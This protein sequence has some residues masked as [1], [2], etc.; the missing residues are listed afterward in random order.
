MTEQFKSGNFPAPRQ[1]EPEVLVLIQKMQQQLIFL[2]KKIDILI[3]QSQEKPVREKSFSKPFRSFDR[4]YSSGPYRGKRGPGE[5]SKER[6][7]RSGH[8]SEK[9]QGE[10]SRR[11]GGPK[12]NYSDGREN[13]SS[14]DRHFKKKYG[15]KKR[16]FGLKKKPSFQKRKD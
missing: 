9:R 13:S 4:P 14:Q 2:E 11:F 1:T 7:F 10:E 3:N 5:D 6:S 8:Y 16:G 15:E 12:R